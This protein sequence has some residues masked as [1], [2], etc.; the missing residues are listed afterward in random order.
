[1]IGAKGGVYPAIQK[2]VEK[3]AHAA[4]FRRGNA[5]VAVESADVQLDSRLDEE[6]RWFYRHL[7]QCAG[8]LSTSASH[9]SGL[10]KELEGNQPI[11]F[12]SSIVHAFRK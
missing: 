3:L 7:K 8:N 6:V 9:A 1:M 4:G 10:R 5:E 11:S 2:R 12:K